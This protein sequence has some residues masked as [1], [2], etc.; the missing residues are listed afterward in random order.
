[1]EKR[2]QIESIPN[3]PPGV[4]HIFSYQLEDGDEECQ[5]K[6]LVLSFACHSNC[7][8]E[9]ALFD[10]NTP[11]PIS[12]DFIQ[13]VN[14]AVFAGASQAILDRTTTIRVPRGFTL[15]VKIHNHDIIATTAALVTCFH[16]KVLS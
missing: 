8:V 11:A 5:I 7:V 4:S 16:Y 10:A 3:I 14:I 9:W 15:G 13:D 1:M 2:V 12:S 6:R